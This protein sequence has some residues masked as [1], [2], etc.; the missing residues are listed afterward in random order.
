MKLSITLEQRLK[1]LEAEHAWI[2]QMLEAFG[3]EG[4]WLSPAK[5]ATALGLSRDRIM[6]EIELAEQYR[7]KNKRGDVVYGRHYRNI[8]NPLTSVKA[9]WQVN[10]VEFQKV[11]E[12]P[13]DERRFFDLP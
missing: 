6:D 4:P 10:V 13:P 12:I 8:Q 1:T 11:L 9:A 5:A 2:R 7:I 3:L